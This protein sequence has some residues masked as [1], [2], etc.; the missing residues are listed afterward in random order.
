MPDV[1]DAY[2][3]TLMAGAVTDPGVVAVANDSVGSSKLGPFIDRFPER[4]FNVGI[5][6]QNLVGFSA[7]LAAG[8]LR[9]WVNSATCFLSFRALEQIK[10]DVVYS[11][12]NVK[13]VGN[14]SGVDY[15]ALGAT[16]HALEDLG[17]LRA[18]PG[19]RIVIPADMCEAR[20]ATRCFLADEA[21]GFLRLYRSEVP[22]DLAQPG[23]LDS[24]CVRPLRRGDAATIFACGGMVVRALDAARHLERSGV[25]VG[26]INVSTLAPLDVDG[27]IE[28][29]A[30]SGRAVTVEEH[31]IQG[32]LG[33]AVC[34]AL[35]EHA[36]MPV[37][38]IGFEAFAIPGPP[39]AIRERC[40]LT[41]AGIAERVLAFV[42]QR[43]VSP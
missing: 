30:V 35:A 29:A 38:R 43:S 9:P 3:G 14:T 28:A 31:M 7:G 4:F 10:D 36:P 34:E 13:L 11:G 20:E 19:L 39:E 12:R 21:P 42:Q 32:G 24:G 23:R 25:K 18:L 41:A 15:G 6:E 40:G 37:L 27:I 1:R 33:S 16:H 26:V 2:I 8:G 17:T 5:A 22:D